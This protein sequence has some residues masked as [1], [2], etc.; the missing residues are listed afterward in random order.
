[1]PILTM[2]DVGKVLRT[3]KAASAA[4]VLAIGLTGCISLGED[5]PG[6]GGARPEPGVAANVATADPS[7]PIAK[8]TFDSAAAPGAKVE[9]GVVE[10]RVTGKLAQLTLSITPRLPGG[11]S[12]NV[13]ELNGNSDPQVSLIDTV[14][15]K[16]YVVVKD[17][18]GKQLQPDYIFVRLRNGQPNVQTYMFA[19]LPE[20][21][22][23]VD[24]VFGQW[25]PFRNVP[26]TR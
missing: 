18:S 19:A 14:N 25:P 6:G 12:P 26:V 13:Y 24:L 3:G 17:S 20:G 7:K 9:I 16:R 1:M 8:A 23:T 5:E 11:R 4:V 15:L 22:R 21:V 10:L 2:E